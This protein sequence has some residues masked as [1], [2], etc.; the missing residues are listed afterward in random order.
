MNNEFNDESIRAY[1]RLAYN[2]AAEISPDPSTQVGALLIHPSQQEILYG[3]NHLL[4]GY[5]KSPAD[6]TDRARKYKIIEHAERD[7]IYKAARL[8]FPTNEAIMV[9][10]WAACT[11]CAR[12]ICLSGVKR[13]ISHA[14]ALDQTPSRWQE[15]LQMAKEIF[16]SANVEYVFWR[17]SVGAC[18]NLF[19]GAY[20]NP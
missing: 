3:V 17:G 1:M 16:K 9:C 10:P 6:L 20:W 5:P 13:V 8:G 19:N 12:A 15:D 14:D 11:D 4:P 7:V 2:L 18:R